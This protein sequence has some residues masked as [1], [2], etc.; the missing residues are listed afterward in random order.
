MKSVSFFPGNFNDQKK[1]ND[2]KNKNKYQNPKC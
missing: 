2:K 1:I